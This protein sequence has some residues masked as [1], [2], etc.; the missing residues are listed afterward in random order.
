M[1][2]YASRT[3]KKLI[4]YLGQL[5]EWFHGKIP[6]I[7][8]LI[9]GTADKVAELIQKAQPYIEQFKNLIGSIWEKAGPALQEFGNILLD[10]AGKAIG[11]A[12]AIVEN[13]DRI[14]PVVYTVVGA[15]A[16]YKTVMF[17]STGYTLA[18]VAALK[19]KAVWDALQIARTNGMTVSQW[20]LNAAMNANP[21]GLV[22]AG[23]AALVGIV[24]VS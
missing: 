16:A 11:I 9:L 10:G 3:R 22:I 18:M 2:R 21:I 23:I 20:A 5:A 4:P 19:A 12:K 13:W 8:D 17:I 14:S 24:W 7:Q 15:L 6:Q 1:G